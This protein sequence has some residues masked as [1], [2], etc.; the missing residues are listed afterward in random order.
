M[1]EDDDIKVQKIRLIGM[2]ERLNRHA[3]AVG[4]NGKIKGARGVIQ[5]K[6]VGIDNHWQIWISIAKDL[7]GQRY[8]VRI[9]LIQILLLCISNNRFVNPMFFI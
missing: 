6:K 4:Q 9:F 3:A 5:L 7:D 2:V 1:E 8:D